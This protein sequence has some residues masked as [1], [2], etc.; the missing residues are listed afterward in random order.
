MIILGAAAAD[1]AEAPLVA[2]KVPLSICISQWRQILCKCL[3]LKCVCSG[4]GCKTKGVVVSCIR[5]PVKPLH[6]NGCFEFLMVDII[7]SVARNGVSS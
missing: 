2:K 3:A 4:F 7:I 1:I 5:L 6:G